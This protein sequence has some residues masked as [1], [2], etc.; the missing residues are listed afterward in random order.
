MAGLAVIAWRARARRPRLEIAVSPWLLGSL[1]AAG[2]LAGQAGLML[3]CHMRAL[4]H[5]LL[6]HARGV[7]LAAVLAALAARLRPSRRLV[8]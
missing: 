4:G 2:A 6:F 1:G 7:A 5:E 8:A 3:S